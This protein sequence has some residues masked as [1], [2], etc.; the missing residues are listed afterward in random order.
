VLRHREHATG[1]EHGVDLFDL[2]H[3]ADE[4]EQLLVG[5]VEGKHVGVHRVFR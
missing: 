3:R 5:L 1:G 4:A 2:A